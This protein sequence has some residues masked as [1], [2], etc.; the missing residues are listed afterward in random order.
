MLSIAR[1]PHTLSAGE[2]FLTWRRPLGLRLRDRLRPGP[3]GAAAHGLDAR[4]ADDAGLAPCS[5]DWR[6]A[7]FRLDPRPFWGIGHTPLPMCAVPPPRA[8]APLEGEMAR[9]LTAAP[10]GHGRGVHAL[11]VLR[12][13]APGERPPHHAGLEE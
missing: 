11:P 5:T 4:L 3:R 1:W 7:G 12:V 8:H 2:L 10:L 6:F 9:D 13:T